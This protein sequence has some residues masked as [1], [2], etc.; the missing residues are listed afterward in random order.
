MIYWMMNYEV[1]L[2]ILMKIMGDELRRQ[3]ISKPKDIRVDSRLWTKLWNILGSPVW[4]RLDARL[5]QRLAVKVIKDI[6][7]MDESVI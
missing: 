1:I 4:T 6:E 3:F 2:V 5:A 7:V